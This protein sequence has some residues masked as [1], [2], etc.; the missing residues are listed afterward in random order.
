MIV[1]SCVVSLAQL[2]HGLFWYKGCV[3]VIFMWY[4]PRIVLQYGKYLWIVCSITLQP[5]LGQGCRLQRLAKKEKEIIASQFYSFE[6]ETWSHEAKTYINT[7][8][9][10]MFKLMLY[11]HM[12]VLCIVWWK[13]FWRF[14]EFCEN[15]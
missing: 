3:S 15:S 5:I 2:E 13:H 7:F 10:S 12:I 9:T 6:Y 11:I 14:M 4:I 8:I 1:G